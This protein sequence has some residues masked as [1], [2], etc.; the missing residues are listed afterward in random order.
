MRHRVHLHTSK[1]VN[2]PFVCYIKPL[3]S[4]FSSKTTIRKI[5]GETRIV[6]YVFSFFFFS[7]KNPLC[8]CIRDLARQYND[9]L[10]LSTQITSN[11]YILR[12][13]QFFSSSIESSISKRFVY[14]FPNEDARDREF[15]F[16]NT[17]TREND[18]MN[19]CWSSSDDEIFFDLLLL[20]KEKRKE[21]TSFAIF[22]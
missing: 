17:M 4:R 11:H 20:K 8:T 12:P 6:T 7:S 21:L 10:S 18:D 2:A 15:E 22:V 1:G 5:V 13:L 16:I 3:N 9:L 14:Y 19:Y